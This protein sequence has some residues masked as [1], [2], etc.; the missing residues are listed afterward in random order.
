M[1]LFEEDREKLEKYEGK[2]TDKQWQNIQEALEDIPR[3]EFL[4]IP[5]TLNEMFEKW[6]KT[7]CHFRPLNRYEQEQEEYCTNKI[8]YPKD[9]EIWRV[10]K[11]S[12]FE[13]FGLNLNGGI[14]ED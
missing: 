4:D 13:L 3:Y 2:I 7:N 5:E 10:Q 11:Q 12:Y 6:V 8:L 1:Q 9:S 14:I